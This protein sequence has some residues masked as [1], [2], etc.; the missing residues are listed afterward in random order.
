MAEPISIQQLKDASEDAISLADFIN[1][2]ANVMIPRRLAADINSLQYYLDYM[3]SY[4]QH[5]Y[6]TYDEM[7]ANAVNLSENVSVFVTNDLDTSKNG[8]YTY[9]GNSFVKGEYQPENAAKE[10]VESKLGGLQVFDGKVRAQDVSTVDGG[11]QEE[12]NK[13]TAYEY[14]TVA[15]MVADA[16]LTADSVVATTG[17]NTPNDNGG[18][19]YIISNTATDYSIPLVN[20]LHAVFNDTFDIRKFG[21]LDNP[22]VDQDINL[23]RMTNY[24]DTREYEIDFHNY[25]I[26]VPATELFTTDRGDTVRGIGFN[27]VH[28]LKN[29]NLKNNDSITQAA[30]LCCVGFYPKSE[31]DCA[32]VFRIN[33]FKCDA[34]LTDILGNTGAFD[35]MMLGFT[36]MPHPDWGYMMWNVANV[37]T[38]PIEF[39]FEDIHF[40]TPAMSYNMAVSSW[41]SRKIVANNLS[42]DYVG[43]YLL[44]FA[45][46]KDVSKVNV[47]YRKD[48]HAARTTNKDLVTSAIHQEPE[49]GSTGSAYVQSIKLSDI[50]VVD[51]EGNLGLAYWHW[52]HGAISLNEIVAKDIHGYVSV[53]KAY[54]MGGKI[55]TLKAENVSGVD[56]AYNADRVILKTVMIN[57]YQRIKLHPSILGTV[58]TLTT[59]HIKNLTIEDIYIEGELFVPF[60][61]ATKIDNLTLKNCTYDNEDYFIK[62]AGAMNVNIENVKT[63]DSKKF[64]YANMP[65]LTIDGLKSTAS[66]VLNYIQDDYADTSYTANLRNLDFKNT[67]GI[68]LNSAASVDISNS[69]LGDTIEGSFI[70]NTSLKLS[71]VRLKPITKTIPTVTVAPAEIYGVSVPVAGVKLGSVV[72]VSANKDIGDCILSAKVNVAGN[73]KVTLYNTTASEVTFTDLQYIIDIVSI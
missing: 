53:S 39:H 58:Y 60:D 68:L 35:G 56:I 65:N 51:N 22:N 9:N 42:G 72:N 44:A 48:L 10:F 23:L 24:A 12:V 71:D 46:I 47:V 43:L 67:T 55:G 31:A 62:V 8:I 15:D 19:K 1:K 27:K 49:L 17:Y 30:G 32:G 14:D 6:E 40:T 13:R 5:S 21:I 2:P 50:R 57:P 18:A 70:R 16:K 29:L 34:Q 52:S 69:V 28:H 25:A 45:H 33:G 38:M 61:E 54:S 26:R 4:A 7:V 36:A 63:K 59:S 3:S 41:K 20:G 37:T 64:L 66:S 73:V 11:T